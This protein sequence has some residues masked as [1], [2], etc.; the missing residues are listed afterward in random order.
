MSK[1][2]QTD[3]EKRRA[4]ELYENMLR[5]QQVKK[6]RVADVVTEALVS[7][8]NFKC[9]VLHITNSK[10]IAFILHTMP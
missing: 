5:S 7:H 8:E 4:D 10:L 6:K 9:F 3:Y 2:E 1:Q